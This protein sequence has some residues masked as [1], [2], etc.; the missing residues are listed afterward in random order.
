MRKVL[1]SAAAALAIGGGFS[2]TSASAAPV[3]PSALQPSIIDT[4]LTEDVQWR[5]R[6]RHHWRSSR[7]VCW[8]GWRGGHHWRWSRRW[9]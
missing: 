7:V 1:L 5:R 2:M 9:R 4:D 6:C 3:T 8:R